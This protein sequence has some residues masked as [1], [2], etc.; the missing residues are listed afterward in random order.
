MEYYNFLSD[1]KT[2]LDFAQ[3]PLELYILFRKFQLSY[4]NIV[5]PLGKN[6]F[7]IGI[8]SLMVIISPDRS[9]I[10]IVKEVINSLSNSLSYGIF[11][12]GCSLEGLKMSPWHWHNYQA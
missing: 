1:F 8:K 5:F 3:T 6:Y 12:F 11:G 10:F 4:A 7:P 2:S 9:D